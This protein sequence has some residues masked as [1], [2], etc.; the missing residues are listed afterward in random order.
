MDQRAAPDDARLAEAVIAGFGGTLPPRLG[1]AVSGGGDSLALMFLLEGICATTG[2][3][4]CVVTVDHGLRPEAADEA[5]FVARHAAALGLSHDTLEWRGWDGQGNLQNAAR[6]ARFGLM[7]EWAQRKDLP[8]VALGHTADDQA[9]TLL[10]RLARRAGVDGLSGVAPQSQRLGTTWARPLLGLR[11][12]ALR[13]YLRRRGVNWVDDPSND[14]PRYARIR[15][16]HTLAAVEPLGV[17]PEALADVAANMASARAALDHYADRAAAEIL[18]TEAGAVVI[19][20][21]GLFALPEETRRRLILRALS[22][23][24]GNVYPPRRAA[25]TALIDGLAQERTGTLDGCQALCRRG[26]IWVFREFNAVRDHTTLIDALWDNRWRAQSATSEQP[27]G[28]QLRAL[29]PQGL[30]QCAA[31]REMQRPR[32]VLLS[33]PAI[34]QGDKLLAAPLAGLGHKWHVQLERGAAWLKTAPLSH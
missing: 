20:A 1:V 6:E 15:T 23:I 12:E 28:L 3:Q 14:D 17:D 13:D 29:G 31:W 16:R 27:S 26:K 18:H 30:V 11:R 34:W 32:A 24:N 4:L 25:V 19:D 33:T 7:A 9:E 2:S 21:K 5:R 8:V 10:M 22:W